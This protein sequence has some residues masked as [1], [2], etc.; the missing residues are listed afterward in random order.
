M[1]EATQEEK[2]AAV[3]AASK[4]FKSWSETP[5]PS[6]AR[7]MFNFQQLIQKHTVCYFQ[8]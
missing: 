1:P 8:F 3:E 5:L 2:E 7:V 6:R 4:A